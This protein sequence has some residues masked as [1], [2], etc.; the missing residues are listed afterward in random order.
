[1][2]RGNV[3]RKNVGHTGL[4]R[5]VLRGNFALLRLYLGIRKLLQKLRPAIAQR[6]RGSGPLR[7]DQRLHSPLP[8]CHAAK[9]AGQCQASQ[10]QGLPFC[11][12][13]CAAQR[14]AGFLRAGIAGQIQRCPLCAAARI[15]RSPDRQRPT[16]RVL[17]LHPRHNAP[18]RALYHRISLAV[19]LFCGTSG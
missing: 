3:R 10:T 6:Q 17:P 9:A 2:P 4:H 7:V 14:R 18:L 1:M 5:L 8:A 11:L 16:G 12:R 19:Q 15:G 13:F